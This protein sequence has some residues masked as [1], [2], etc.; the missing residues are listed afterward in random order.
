[1]SVKS[2]P[3]CLHH[4]GQSYAAGANE[5]GTRGRVR[6]ACQKDGYGA[7]LAAS[8][9]RM[10]SSRAGGPAVSSYGTSGGAS[11]VRTAHPE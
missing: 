1:M 8:S 4:G 6:A 3:P 10:L 7:G 11:G 2:L 5:W 9:Q